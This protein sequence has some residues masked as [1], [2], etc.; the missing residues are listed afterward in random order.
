M[1]IQSQILNIVFVTV[2]NSLLI[3][4]PVSSLAPLRSQ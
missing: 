4:L 3:V 1:L 2:S